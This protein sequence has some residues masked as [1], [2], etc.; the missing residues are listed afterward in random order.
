MRPMRH[1]HRQAERGGTRR[2]GTPRSLEK[3]TRNAEHVV[4][5][6]KG[7]GGERGDAL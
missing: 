3:G 1:C 2:V 4:G 7:G 6:S 5:A